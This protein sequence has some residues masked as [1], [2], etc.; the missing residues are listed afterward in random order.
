MVKDIVKY[1]D[2]LSV[3]YA[4]DVRIF[5]E[6]LFSLIDDLKDTMKENNL[7]GL[8]AFQI[9]S[10]Y[11]VVVIKGENQEYLELINPRLISHNGSVIT[12]ETTAYYGDR[13]ANIKRYK[14][15]SIVYQDRDAKDRS[16]KASG[17]LSIL[18]QRKIDYTFGATFIHKMDAQEKQRFENSLELG[19]DIQ[20]DESCPTTFHRDKILK[21]INIILVLM[22][23]NLLVSFLVSNELK[24]ILWNAQL[25]A[26]LGVVFLNIVYF[27]YAQYEGKKY[28]NCMSCQIGNI[29]GTSALSFIKLSLL[30]L[31]SYF[32]IN[33]N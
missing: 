6:E 25:Y 19:V 18:I 15:I 13:V 16:L 4:T 20:S 14:D 10:Y 12:Q 32:I 30:M 23:I 2:T 31:I 17:N 27:F 8:S 29:L 22:G 7:D 24:A 5:N 9:G 3:E 1:P 26:T 21:V 33:P 11:N 28:T